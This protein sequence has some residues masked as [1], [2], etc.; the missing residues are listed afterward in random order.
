MILEVITKNDIE[1]KK[2]AGAFAKTVQL[3]A[4]IS[5]EG[6]L[7]AGKTTFAKGFI[8]GFGVTN[9]VT[10][11]TFT[12][13]NEYKSN[14]INLYH[15][16]MYRLSSFEEARELGFDE[17]FDLK[18]L[19]GIVLVEWAENVKRILPAHYFKISFEKIDDEKRKISIEEIK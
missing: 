10:S 11:P 18:K 3:P 12:L 15:F 16:D 2:F 5:L 4:V 9:L 8:A 17:Y 6:D 13:L 14:Q 7:G 19:N 1:T